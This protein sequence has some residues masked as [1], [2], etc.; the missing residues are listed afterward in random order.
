MS[1]VIQQCK[2]IPD[3]AK[4]YNGRECRL[5]KTMLVIICATNYKVKVNMVFR[6]PRSYTGIEKYGQ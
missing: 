1:G 3:G 4:S 2:T 5:F 6:K